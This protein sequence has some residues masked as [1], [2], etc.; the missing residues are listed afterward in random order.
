MAVDKV[1]LYS[2]DISS[3]DPIETAIITCSEANGKVVAFFSPVDLDVDVVPQVQ[4][5]D[6]TWH[7]IESATTI[8]DGVPDALVYGFNPGNMRFLVT[9][10]DASGSLTA[11]A[12]GY[13]S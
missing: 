8:A 7:A 1:T 6:G 10:S 11:W 4:A 3:T 9:P 12:N 13:G 2:G 5:P